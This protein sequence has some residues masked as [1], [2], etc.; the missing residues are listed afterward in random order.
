MGRFA[1]GVAVITAE[2]AGQVRGMTASAC[3]SGSLEPPLIVVSVA[4]CAVMHAHLLAAGRF[5]VN[6]LCAGQRDVATHFAGRALPAYAPEFSYVGTIPTLG[7][8]AT[9][10]TAA[11]AATH[12]CGDH[13]IFV[14]RILTM[15]ADDSP[16]LV[17]HA[18]KFG[19]LVAAV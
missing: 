3:M 17:Y 4:K 1:S 16:P 8:V 14:G 11:T 13:T 7:S 18:G 5:A 2:A 15:T 12:E 6:I 19:V 9:V 10:I